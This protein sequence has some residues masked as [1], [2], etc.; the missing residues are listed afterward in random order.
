MPEEEAFWILVTI[1]EDL[2][3]EYYHKELLGSLVDQTV[4][5]DLIAKYYPGKIKK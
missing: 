5:E 4:F 2:V 1:C 3:P